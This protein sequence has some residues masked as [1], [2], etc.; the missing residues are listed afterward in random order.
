MAGEPQQTESVFLPSPIDGIDAISSP[1]ELPLTT[2]RHLDNYYC[3]DWGIRRRVAG[4]E[5]TSFGSTPPFHGVSLIIPYIRKD[6]AA[7]GTE[8][9]L[10]SAQR[11]LLQYQAK[12]VTAPINFTGTLT[13]T[14]NINNFCIFNDRIFLVNGI[15]APGVITLNPLAAAVP[16]VFTGPA[17]LSTLICPTAFHHRLYFIEKNTSKLWYGG[18]DAI[19]G[20]LTLFDL[21]TVFQ[22]GGTLTI[23]TTVA[24][25]QGIGSEEF[26]V[27]ISNIGEVLIYSGDFPGDVESWKLVGRTNIPAP[28]STRAHIRVAQDVYVYTMR[29][30]IALSRVF[31]SESNDQRYYTVSNKLGPNMAGS[32]P[33]YSAVRPGY[34]ANYPFLYFVGDSGKSL[35]VMNYERGAWSRFTYDASFIPYVSLTR[36]AAVAV[37]FGSLWV[38]TFDTQ[39]KLFRFDDF[40]PAATAAEGGIWKTPYMGF[41]TGYEKTSRLVR[42][43]ARDVSSAPDAVITTQLSIATDF[44]STDLAGS[45]SAQEHHDT[46]STPKPVVLAGHETDPPDWVVQELA[47]PGVGRNLSFIFVSRGGGQTELAGAEVTF[48]VG[49][50]Y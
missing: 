7:A 23:L 45:Y 33:A 25:N 13:L 46:V 17:S 42:V 24:L 49:G 3:F 14:Q 29:G 22:Q 27:A 35:Y 4:V 9:M 48:N 6:G 8:A 34:N 44:K 41:G 43:L 19:T 15:D 26:L 38:G 1:T 28:L 30:V 50:V 12:T 20:V 36:V 31:A 21:A 10:V 11:Q 39:C 32:E 16:A 5:Q 40:D 18:V 37:A 47:P 2:A